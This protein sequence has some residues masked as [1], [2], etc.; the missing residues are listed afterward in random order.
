M[1]LV[2]RGTH[3]Q[4]VCRFKQLHGYIGNLRSRHRYVARR[5]VRSVDVRVKIAL[6]QN[7]TGRDNSEVASINSVTPGG[8]EE[9]DLVLDKFVENS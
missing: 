6:A 8:P 7:E 2:S 1:P 9:F 5:L 3:A 4:G